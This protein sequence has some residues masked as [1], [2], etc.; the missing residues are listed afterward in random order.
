MDIFHYNQP[1]EINGYSIN[2][3]YWIPVNTNSSCNTRCS[4][5]A[6]GSLNTAVSPTPDAKDCYTNEVCYNNQLRNTLYQ[7]TSSNVRLIDGKNLYVIQI[8][9]TCNLLIGC[10]GLMYFI[11][12]TY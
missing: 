8:I 7:S 4:A 9:H 5:N 6:N 11:K 10:A 12:G 3:Q 1:K 2:D